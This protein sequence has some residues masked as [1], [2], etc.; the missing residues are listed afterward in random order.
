MQTHIETVKEKWFIIAIL[1]INKKIAVIK[2]MIVNN[3]L[4]MLSTLVYISWNRFLMLMHTHE[5]V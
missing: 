2:F 5:S 1:C 3:H 4:S